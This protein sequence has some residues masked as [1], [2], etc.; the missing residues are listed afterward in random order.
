VEAT[1]TVQQNPPPIVRLTALA[2]DFAGLMDIDVGEFPT[3]GDWYGRIEW[4]VHSPED[5]SR[6][7]NENRAETKFGGQADLSLNYDG[8]GNLNGTLRGSWQVDTFWWGYPH[9]DGRMQIFAADPVSADIV[10]SYTPGPETVTLQPSIW[11]QILSYRRRVWSCPGL[12][13]QYDDRSG[14]LFQPPQRAS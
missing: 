2:E 5:T 12:V 11:W 10:G 8:R 6:R 7:S 14:A 9:G 13:V 1:Y 3:Q 4:S